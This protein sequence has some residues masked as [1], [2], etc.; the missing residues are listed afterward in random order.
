MRPPWSVL[1]ECADSQLRLA[2]AGVPRIAFRRSAV[3]G[4]AITSHLGE[5]ADSVL[6]VGR[7]LERESVVEHRVKLGFALAGPVVAVL[8][9]VGLSFGEQLLRFLAQY[10]GRLSFDRN[11]HREN[12][13]D[14]PEESRYTLERTPPGVLRTWNATHLSTSK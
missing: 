6:R 10:L 12:S 5:L 11:G 8:L 3:A 4:I 13:S 1:A 9:V 2:L 14:W 7:F